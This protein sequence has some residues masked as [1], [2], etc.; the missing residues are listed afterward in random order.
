M[1][2]V[3]APGEQ[4]GSAARETLLN[5]LVDQLLRCV[6]ENASWISACVAHDDSARNV[7]GFGVNAGQFQCRPIS[8]RLVTVVALNENWSGSRHCVNELFSRKLRFRPF[9]FIPATAQNPFAFRRFSHLRRDALR[10]LLRARSISKLN[11]I[12]LR[13]ALNEMH[14]RVVEARQHQL[15]A[16]IDHFRFW[17]EPQIDLRAG[18]DSHYAI[19]DNSYG[20]GSG[21]L[22]IYCV[23]CG[24]GD[25]QR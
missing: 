14:V 12:E 25:D 24:I 19:A 8:E 11:L 5:R 3:P 21:M 23:N 10:E 6:L 20:F 13:S 9:G 15:A 16:R 2:R 18:A 1:L 22:F 7:R 17:T 4:R